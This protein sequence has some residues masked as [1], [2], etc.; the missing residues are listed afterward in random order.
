MHAGSEHVRAKRVEEDAATAALLEDCSLVV[1]ARERI[2]AC[3]PAAMP[4][5]AASGTDSAS[6]ATTAS[7][8]CGSGSAFG[9]GAG[10]ALGVDEVAERLLLDPG[11]A[12]TMRTF[13]CARVEERAWNDQ[14]PDPKGGRERL[15]RR[16]G[17]DDPPGLEPLKRPH[18]S[19]KLADRVHGDDRA[20][21]LPA[22]LAETRDPNALP[23]VGR[24]RRSQAA[25]A[26]LTE[27][28]STDHVE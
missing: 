22:V 24:S 23:A 15:A 3:R 25:V 11:R 9:A 18:G 12:R 5:T 2:A 17:V 21:E 6:A 4:C 26:R 28:R 1:P 10:R 13:S 8:R 19:A 16:A 27:E 14:P 20:G 7:R